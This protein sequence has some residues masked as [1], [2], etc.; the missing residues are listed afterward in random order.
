MFG[1]WKVFVPSCGIAPSTL[2]ADI[3]AALRPMPTQAEWEAEELHQYGEW[4][5]AAPAPL[6]RH[7]LR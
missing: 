1:W 7:Q 3:L 6:K 5:E 4:S 2:P